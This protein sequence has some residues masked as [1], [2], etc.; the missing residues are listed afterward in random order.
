M[1]Q[2]Y[3]LKDYT[4]EKIVEDKAKIAEIYD[5]FG[6]VI[7]PGLFSKYDIYETYLSD[8]RK[9]MGKIIRR[10]TQDPLPD[11]IGELLIALVKHQPLDGRIITDI[12]T[13]PNKFF[14]FNQL[15][16]AGWIKALVDELFGPDSITLT[17]Q[18]GD[19]LHFFP[20]GEKFHRY[21][22]PP[23]Q[24]Y[25]YLM[26]SPKQMTFYMGI[27][28]YKEGVGGLKIWEKSHKLG[29]LKSTTN[30]FGAYEVYDWEKTLQDYKTQDL[31]WNAGDF[32]VFDSLLAHSSIPST[33]KTASRVVGIF[34]FSDINHPV[35]E[36]YD[37]YSTTYDRRG[38][39]FMDN[40]PELFVPYS[41][42]TDKKT[43]AA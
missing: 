22:L 32:G 9:V 40:N 13:Q 12:G 18:A 30:E 36:S 38:V 6:A 16:Y 5:E 42:S 21:N 10:H 15:K 8:L 23:H 11:D 26:Q 41:P 27:S 35:A 24:D 14:S 37:Y 25:Q 28:D 3:I 33:S 2:D 31:F 29:V 39:K 7:F 20:P 4:V 19:T 17:P 1:E 43:D 34:R